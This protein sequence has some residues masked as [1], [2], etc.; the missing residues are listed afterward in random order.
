MHT[1]LL[2][3]VHL[4]RQSLVVT[5]LACSSTGH[6]DF[7]HGYIGCTP[8]LLYHTWLHQAHLSQ[9]KALKH[10]R[11]WPFGLHT[12]VLACNQ[13]TRQRKAVDRGI[14]CQA[15]G[16]RFG[17]FL[18]VGGSAINRHQLCCSKRRV[19]KFSTN[20]RK[21]RPKGRT[22]KQSAAAAIGD[23]CGDSQVNTIADAGMPP[24]FAS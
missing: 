14:V 5:C 22:G 17:W 6:I 10:L 16:R 12:A 24:Y 15:A 20:R 1:I 21:K 9:Y 7:C 13:D 11:S 23:P 3:F 18:Q 8:P 4:P 19:A 2:H